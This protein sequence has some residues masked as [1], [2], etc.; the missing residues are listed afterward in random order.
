MPLTVI[1]AT[2]HGTGPEMEEIWAGLQDDLAALSD[3]S[4]HVDSPATGHY[5]HLENPQLVIDEI[6]TLFARL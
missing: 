3:Y 4:R 6:V 2:E 1:S 5:V